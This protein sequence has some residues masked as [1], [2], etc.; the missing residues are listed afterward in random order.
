[1]TYFGRVGQPLRKHALSLKAQLWIAGIAIGVALWLPAFLPYIASRTLTAALAEVSRQYSLWVA[2]AATLSVWLLSKAIARV[3]RALRRRSSGFGEI[4]EAYCVLEAAAIA[5]FCLAT[6]YAIGAL[7]LRQRVLRSQEVLRPLAADI[8]AYH[9]VSKTSMATSLAPPFAHVKELSNAT[10]VTYRARDPDVPGAFIATVRGPEAT[11]TWEIGRSVVRQLALQ[12]GQVK[13]QPGN[14][15]EFV[16]ALGPSLQVRESYAR[17]AL[18]DGEEV[19]AQVVSAGGKASVVVLRTL[20]LSQIRPGAAASPPALL[21]WLDQPIGEA[22]FSRTLV[23]SGWAL[24]EKGLASVQVRIDGQSLAAAIGLP[25]PDVAATQPKYAEAATSGF[26]FERDFA[27]LSPLR[28]P[29]S[30]VAIDR[31]GNEAI[32]GRRS[33]VPPDAMALWSTLRER[34]S[35]PAFHFLMATSGVATG[36]GAELDEVYQGYSSRTQK[37]GVAV[38][39]LYLRTTLGRQGDW[40][41]DPAFDTRRKCGDRVLAE[42]SLDAVFAFAVKTRMPIQFVLNGGIW[43]DAACNVPEWDLNDHLE[44]DPRNCQWSQDNRVFPDDYLK[45]L[46]GSMASPELARSLTLNVYASEVRRYKRRNLQ[47]A[48]SRIAT[49]RREHPDLFVGVNLDSDTYVNPFFEEREWF[50]YNPGT[51]RQFREWLQSTGPYLGQGE[52]GAPDLRRY[53]RAKP[54]TLDEVNRLARQR[55]QKWSEV[56]PPRKFP[57]SKHTPLKDGEISIWDDAWYQ[58]W[59]TFRKQLVAIHYAE[60]AQ[61]VQEAGIPASQIFTTQGFVA[62]EDRSRPFAVTLASAGQNYDSGG[63]SIEGA[64]PRD[65]HLGA[66]LYGPAAENRVRMEHRFGLFATFARMDRSWAVAEMNIADLKHPERQP[67]YDQ[68]YRAFRDMFN[69]DARQATLMAWNGSNGL[70]IGQQ[71]YIAYTSWRNTPA[72]EAMR[73]QL[74]S[75]AGLPLGSRLWTFGT[76][77]HADNDDWTADGGRL[78]GM[79]GHIRV[80]PNAPRLALVSPSDQVIRRRNARELVIGIDPG[81]DLRF[82][83]SAERAPGSGWRILTKPGSPYRRSEAGLHIPLVWPTGWSDDAIAERFKIE[84]SVGRS[85]QPIKVHRIALLG[86]VR[87]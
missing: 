33:L 5:I 53:R 38:P 24:G 55:W 23:T 36:G 42:D 43:A 17:S 26:R 29:F 77:Q 58:T 82:E 78:E 79:T 83:V 69:Y 67:T 45:N 8:L 34:A 31:E 60:L 74:V 19:V 28:Y 80:T 1:M 14:P 70:F 22:E 52:K 39:I 27:S 44:D 86:S 20:A 50:D 51:L 75:H 63:V 66:V 84:W 37:I 21:G 12:V 81:E 76:A 64:I 41:F 32:L 46:S 15:A 85:D 68:A 65:G 49:F 54:L 2:I 72:E 9:F 73:D 7:E 16:S 57:G 25:R 10:T 30:V 62:P 11:V 13:T 56:D 35:G 59:D 47:A 87:E 4:V 18:A 6:F 3:G 40:K 48:A 71:G 61:W